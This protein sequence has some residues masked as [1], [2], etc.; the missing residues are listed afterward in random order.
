V[1]VHFGHHLG[2]LDHASGQVQALAAQPGHLPDAQASI[3]AK[4]DQRPVGR[5]DGHGQ[6]AHLG[7][8]QEPHFGSLDLGQGDLA[9]WRAGDHAPSTAA[10]R[11]L[12][13][14]W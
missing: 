7:H 13:R 2:D 8:G 11:I 9:A 12:V 4:Q 6:A 3:G 5:P 1:A 14:I 10:A